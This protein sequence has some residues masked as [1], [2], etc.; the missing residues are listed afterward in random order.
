MATPPHDLA[1]MLE[2]TASGGR[3]V[4]RTAEGA[5]SEMTFAFRQDG[6]LIIDHTGVP[7]ELEGRGIAAA[8]LDHAL[9]YVRTH[10]LKIVPHC[11]YVAAAF[12]RHPDWS[13]ALA[14]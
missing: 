10:G 7:T 2:Q 3:W 8:L 9:E 6:A 11:S 12:R 13:D 5:D 14:R 4:A 1:I